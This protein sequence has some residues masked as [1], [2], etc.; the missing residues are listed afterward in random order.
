MLFD[1]SAGHT[2]R[3]FKMSFKTCPDK[4]FRSKLK[5]D[6]LAAAHRPEGPRYQWP[7]SWNFKNLQK[8]PFE[9]VFR[10]KMQKKNFLIFS[11]WPLIQDGCQ[12]V[13]HLEKSKV[14]KLCLEM[15]KMSKNAK[16]NFF[17]FFQYGRHHWPTSVCRI[18]KNVTYV[19]CHT[20][21]KLHTKNEAISFI[22]EGAR[23]KKVK[24]WLFKMAARGIDRGSRNSNLIKSITYIFMS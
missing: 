16:K 4:P 3:S 2:G 10:Q 14:S 9:S 13:S 20:L 8:R 21:R 23:A 11:R 1:P 5:L 22:I 18:K 12:G 7:P 17:D 24:K 19:L 15:L 6:R